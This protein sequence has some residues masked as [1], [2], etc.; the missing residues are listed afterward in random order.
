MSYNRRMTDP[1]EHH[2]LRD[3]I[4]FVLED[5]RNGALDSLEDAIDAIMEHPEFGGAWQLGSTA[6]K[7]GS[8]FLFRVRSMVD[9]T[10][11]DPVVGRFTDEQLEYFDGLQWKPHEGK[12]LMWAAIVEPPL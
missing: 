11:R 5:Y 2:S 7:D 1:Y 8:L 6:P 4:G 3:R 9:A 10:W 12:P